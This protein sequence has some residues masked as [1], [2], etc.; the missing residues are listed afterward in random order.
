MI[1]SPFSIEHAKIP[2]SRESTAH[3]Q[4]T[5][6][7][8]QLPTS[9]SSANSCQL[10]KELHMC[11]RRRHSFLSY[12]FI[13]FVLQSLELKDYDKQCQDQEVACAQIQGQHTNSRWKKSAGGVADSTRW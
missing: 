7:D 6:H 8:N 13:C 9:V 3:F 2:E 10:T 11:F 4:C 12:R 5:N 1:I